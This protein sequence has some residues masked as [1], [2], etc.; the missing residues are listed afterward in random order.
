[1]CVSG[2]RGVPSSDYCA[3][4]AAFQGVDRRFSV[5]GEAD[6]VLVVDDYGHHPTELAATIAAARLHGR[7]LVVAFQPH[8]YSR[9]R[10]LLADFAPALAGAAPVV[11]RDH[12]PARAPPVPR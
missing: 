3:A 9:T 8:R 1:G 12:Y 6:G 2:F 10:D 7:R 4:L 11:L 5:R